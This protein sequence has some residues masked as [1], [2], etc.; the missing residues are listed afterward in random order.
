MFAGANLVA[1]G[2]FDS[3]GGAAATNIAHWDGLKWFAVEKPLANIE[4]IAG[5][6]TN[7]YA[8]ASF[9]SYPLGKVFRWDGFQW[10]PLGK[11]FDGYARVL[12]FLGDDLFAAGRF[13]T[14]DGTAAT[15]IARWDGNQWLSLGAGLRLLEPQCHDCS[16]DD[17]G[18]HGRV[19][20]IA[21][22][23]DQLFAGGKFDWADGV[24]AT[25]IA[26]WDGVRWHALGEGLAD[27]V[28]S[29]AVFQN[30]LY[31]NAAVAISKWN[32]TRWVEVARSDMPGLVLAS[33]ERYLYAGGTFLEIGGIRANRIARWD[34]RNW[35]RLGS[36]L[37]EPEG[38]G[39]YG[40]GTLAS[41]G[42]E[43]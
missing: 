37:S 38:A 36:G 7:I 18:I 28:E 8:A 43:V 42:A 26:R 19:K 30:E 2:Y 17:P 13:R 22:M 16:L 34:G 31:A 20:A 1:A 40:V 4:T 33:D 25:N 41:N 39:P 14:A 5:D 10:L 15:N 3:I 6:G 27:Q 23:G 21:A 35:F 32:G 12:A 24:R 9:P 29:L 11:G